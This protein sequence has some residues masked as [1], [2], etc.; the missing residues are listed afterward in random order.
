[1]MRSVAEVEAVLVKT[2]CELPT[3]T[4]AQVRVWVSRLQSLLTEYERAH[5]R[6]AK[7]RTQAAGEAGKEVGAA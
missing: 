6:A 1:M 7:L 4:P 5:R 2:M 3:L